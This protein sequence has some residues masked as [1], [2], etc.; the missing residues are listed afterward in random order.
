MELYDYVGMALSLNKY[1][2]TQSG[3]PCA[4]IEGYKLA[5]MYDNNPAYDLQLQLEQRVVQQNKRVHLLSSWMDVINKGK[6]IN[7]YLEQNEVKHVVI[8]GCG[9]TGKKL[10]SQIENCKVADVECFI[11][12]KLFGTEYNGKKIYSIE[13][14]KHENINGKYIVIISVVSDIEEIKEKLM[15]YGWD[16]VVS[17]QQIIDELSSL[18]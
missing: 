5:D 13:T 7:D 1:R 16:N 8:Y 6:S 2:A 15:K 9:D 10:F 3:M 11:D 12:K 18:F 14:L 4:Y 17:I